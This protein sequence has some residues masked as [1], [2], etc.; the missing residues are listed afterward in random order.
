MYYKGSWEE[1]AAYVMSP[2][3]RAPEHQKALWGA[4]SGGLI[5]TTATDHCTFRTDQKAMG[6]HDFTLIPNGTGGVE[7]RMSVLYTYGVLPGRLSLPEFVATT[8]S[9]AAKLFGLWPRK[10]AL[11]PGS[12]ADVV[13]LDPT[14]RRTISA[15]THWQAVDRNIWE[16][17]VVQGV[18]TLTLLRGK[19]VW[20]AHLQD[21][22]A[23]WRKVPPPCGPPHVLGHPQLHQGR[24][25]VPGAE[26][27]RSGL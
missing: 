6:R 5:Q 19:V 25:T 20:R 8:S 13:V 12:D 23:D 17:W 24:R 4:L 1:A 2:P 21:G 3:F 27:F 16:G 26:V 14:A 11:L 10:G 7:D 15:Q 22:V 18:T 9:N